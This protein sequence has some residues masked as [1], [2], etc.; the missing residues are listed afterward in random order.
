M[1]TG[2]DYLEEEVRHATGIEAMLA[3]QPRKKTNDGANM[4]KVCE[5]EQQEKAASLVDP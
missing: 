2:V 1:R 5:C 4:W 3:K